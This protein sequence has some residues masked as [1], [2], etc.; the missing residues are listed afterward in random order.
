MT[1]YR[2]TDP[3]RLRTVSVRQRPP[4]TSSSQLAGV[5]GTDRSFRAFVDSL[6]DLLAGKTLRQVMA[7]VAEAHRRKR[8]TIL[9]LG[10]HIIKTGLGPLLGELIARGVVGH[11]AMNGA[12]AIH[13]MELA[14]FG[15]TSEEVEAG[16]A[17]G[18]FG[19]ADETGHTMNLAI[20]Q[21]ATEGKGMGEG[22]AE[23]IA[24]SPSVEVERGS[25]LL[26]CYRH[27]VP[28]TVHPVLG[29]EIIHQHPTANGAAIGATGLRDFRRLAAS[30]EDLHDGGVVLNL[31]SAVV[32]PEVFLKALAVARNLFEGRPTGFLAGNFDMIQ[33]YRA[34]RNVVERPTL[35]EGVGVS[36]TGHHEI[37]IPLLVWGILELLET[38]A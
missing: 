9:L 34:R 32:M 16:L 36:L 4:L 23:A 3:D 18:S 35:G 20:D 19:M 21:A 1:D 26:Q 17:D 15:G 8:A 5:P 14:L 13:D 31:G 7:A 25:V 29:A 28:V 24:K 11:I 33:H 38:N 2:E 10:G 12:A 30:V 6:P 27:N 22:L 37:M